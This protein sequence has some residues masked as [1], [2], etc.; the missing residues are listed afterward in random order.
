ML[1]KFFLKILWS[2]RRD[3]LL[4]VLSGI[5]IIS[6]VF[7]STAVGSFMSFI[8]TG[9]PAA[10]TPLIGDVEKVYL[11]PYILLLFLMLL[12]LLS[13][14]RKRSGD[15]AMLSVLGI[16]TKHRYRFVGMEYLGIILLSVC[17]GTV[18][19][20][21]EA[22]AVRRIL[23][24][25]F[26]DV[27][28]HIPLGWQPF[29]LTLIISLIIF[30]LGFIICDQMICCLGVDAVAAGGR[31]GGKALRKSPVL[32]LAGILT[33]LVAFAAAVTYWG[34]IGSHVPQALAA[35]GLFL[36]M[37]SGGGY[38][39]SQLREHKR[40]YYR[41]LLWLDDWYHRYYYHMNMSYIVAAFLFVIIFSFMLPFFDSLPVTQPE[42]YPHDLVWQAN[43]GDEEF[44]RSLQDRYGVQAETK[45]SLRV[46][47]ADFG[48]HTGI[49]ASEYEAWTGEQI[50]LSDKEIYVV[51]Q[52]DREDMGSIGLDFG[53]EQPRMY[54][55]NSDYDLWIFEG[56]RIQPG[57]QLVREYKIK[58]T[59]NRI[60]TGNFKTRSLNMVCDVFEDIIVFSDREFERIRAGAR[61][62]DLMVIM[63]IPEHY[64]EVAKEVYVYAK[65]HSQVNFYDWRAGNL[66]YEGRR[67]GI[68]SRRQK[69]YGASPMLINIITL[70]MCVLFV[71]IEKVES[72]Y[73]DIAWKY[74]FYCRS[75]MTQKKRKKNLGKEVLMAAKVSL[76]CGL[77]LAYFMAGEKIFDKHMPGEWNLIYL[78]WAAVFGC[79]AAG[80]IYL[81]MKLAARNTCSKIERGNRNGRKR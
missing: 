31:K 46:A 38:Y 59:K 47:T 60:L 22:E 81:V 53:N 42:N 5:F 72:D 64:D 58:G 51:Y 79:G 15:Y 25:I 67:Q 29:K 69:L 62:A 44:L 33:E 4:V 16:Q 6:M 32:L 68:E 7:F 66:I 17:G 1:N 9:E 21:L 75:G 43:E 65:E 80:I 50:E 52:R 76:C 73:E 27:T 71:L 12:I 24:G 14:I 39:L 8:D 37:L 55:G 34:R 20:F 70:F 26:K 35:G 77:S 36:L 54:I 40:A 13:Y 61:G 3:Y 78:A 45:R 23:E 19:G 18:L 10:M 11:L 2:R 56:F 63:D 74:Q 57:N 30:G 28:D 49:S 48:E 41:K